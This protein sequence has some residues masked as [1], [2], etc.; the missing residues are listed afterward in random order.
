MLIQLSDG[1]SYLA[2]EQVRRDQLQAVIAEISSSPSGVDAAS[3]KEV[4]TKDVGDSTVTLIDHKEALSSSSSS[5]NGKDEAFKP[6]GFVIHSFSD[7]GAG[8]LALFLDEMARR[9]PSTSSTPAPKVHS[10]IMDSSPGK[11]NPTTGSVAFTMHLAN[12]PRLR[13]FVRFFVYLGLYLMKI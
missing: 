8:N 9:Y 7:G 2:R 12:R 11:A 6:S 10:L 4:E 3:I 1:K 5:E 13:A